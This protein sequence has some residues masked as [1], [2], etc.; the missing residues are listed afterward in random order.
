MFPVIEVTGTAFERGRQHGTRARARVERSIAHYASLF[1]HCGIR[2][3]D[4]QRL[5]AAYRR[6]IGEFDPELLQEIEG[7]AAG[8]GRAVDEILALNARTEIL[9]PTFPEQPSGEWLAS[10]LG[11]P[12]DLGE[13]M[14][15]R[16]CLRLRP[17]SRSRYRPRPSYSSFSPVRVRNV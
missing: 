15:R 14:S 1:G 13:C 4:A 11:R 3:I 17:T 7:L 12:A 10:R 8:A 2:W 9:P 6:V 16:M 5:G